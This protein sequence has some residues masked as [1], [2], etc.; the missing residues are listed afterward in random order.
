MWGLEFSRSF[1]ESQ[2]ETLILRAYP[3]A[4]TMQ[5]RKDAR[6][7]NDSLFCTE[8]QLQQSTSCTPTSTISSLNPK[9]GLKHNVILQ[10]QDQGK[11]QISN[12]KWP[13]IVDTAWFWNKT[14][15]P[16]ASLTPKN[17][18]KTKQTNKKKNLA[19]L[20][21]LKNL[22]RSWAGLYVWEK[23]F[24]LRHSKPKEPRKNTQAALYILLPNGS[25]RA[26]IL[27]GRKWPV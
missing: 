1:A 17:K 20:M 3:R 2:I 7:F 25:K 6:M 22:H 24:Q 19:S 12:Q 10:A 23:C 5:R 15:S 27:K 14:C 16:F 8:R 4:H 9:V 21:I 26:K 11:F 18:N 13:T